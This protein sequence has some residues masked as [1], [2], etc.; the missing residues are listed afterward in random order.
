M[1][2]TNL[3]RATFV[4]ILTVWLLLPFAM[5]NRV[6]DDAVAFTAA[7]TL[8]V[9]GDGTEVYPQAHN[10]MSDAMLHAECTSCTG[11]VPFI[12]PPPA[13]AVVAPLGWLS[14]QTAQLLLRLLGAVC[15]A[16]AFA[17]FWT[18]FREPA[19]RQMVVAVA[20]ASTPLVIATGQLGQMTP[21]L[22]LALAVPSSSLERR[23]VAVG[24]GALLAAATA[25]KLFP[26]VLVI[27]ALLLGRRLVA[28]VA[29]ALLAAWSA[30][31]VAI[32]PGS[33]GS[34]ITGL[35]LWN[36]GVSAPAATGSVSSIARTLVSG[37]AASVVELVALGAAVALVARSTRAHDATLAVVAT[38]A[39]LA[40]PQVWAHYLFIPVIAALT[41]AAH[42]GTSRIVA[43]LVAIATVP[44]AIATYLS[45]SELANKATAAA[46]VASAG[47]LWIVLQRHTTAVA[48]PPTAASRAAVVS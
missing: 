38:A 34:F 48:R 33:V 25:F 30:I 45:S 31:A 24:V 42:R 10:R 18:R 21:L 3:T 11:G 27:A 9:H 47:A 41:L 4:A 5:Q 12:S 40:W 28:A 20:L 46:L 35:R 19:A 16:G 36:H 1:M 14:Q 17:A 2:S 37:G 6:A 15:L 29:I 39:V 23:W 44:A 13:L 7:G 26:V 43:V 32:A 22:V 8:F